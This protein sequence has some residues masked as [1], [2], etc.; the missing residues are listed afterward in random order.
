MAESQN[1]VLKQNGIANP[2]EHLAKGLDFWTIQTTINILATGWNATPSI[3]VPNYL[4]E[5]EYV[6]NTSQLAL[7]K[8]VQIIG[9][10]GQPVIL[11]APTGTGPYQVTFAIEHNGSW[12]ADGGVV[13]TPVAGTRST[14]L[15]SAIV[16]HGVNFG[17]GSDTPVAVL[18][19]Q[20]A[21]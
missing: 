10:R 1:G 16:A 7:D 20:Y 4:G 9:L 2:G 5:P 12:P 17:F 8:L 18:T 14:S 15:E 11:N 6:E 13:T 19:T 3:T 21:P